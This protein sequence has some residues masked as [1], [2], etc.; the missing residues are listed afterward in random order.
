MPRLSEVIS[1]TYIVC[2]KEDVSDLHAALSE[3]GL[4]PSESRM[5]YSEEE[6]NYH[7]STKCFMNHASVWGK[8][9]S[10]PGY[11]LIVEAD[12][13][14][15]RGLGSLSTFWPTDDPEA[16][17][18]LYQGSPRLLALVGEDE[19]LRAHCSPTVA[20]VINS[21]VASKL[22]DFYKGEFGR[23]DPQT[24]YTFESHMQWWIMGQ[25]GKA[26]MPARHYGEHGGQ[27]NPDHA[28][29]ANLSRQG[30]HHADNLAAPLVFLPQYAE[31]SRLNYFRVRA[32]S[33]LLG[34]G[35]LAT[36]RWVSVT[37]AYD[38]SRRDRLRMLWI[39]IKR[40]AS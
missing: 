37:D 22:V 20:Y 16:W 5:A 35:R 9:A 1:Q 33:K 7:S 27:P 26:Y 2:H 38:L 14:P 34:V 23:H 28:A 12:F 39:G 17:G 19:F 8:A 25:G 32:V 30:E 31:G 11:T 21:V 6:R 40:L 3:E 24:H 18:Y 10:Q 36:G 29:V 15:C 13:V 4:N